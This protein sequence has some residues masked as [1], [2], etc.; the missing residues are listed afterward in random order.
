[1]YE[2]NPDKADKIAKELLLVQAQT[3]WDKT[4]SYAAA[5]QFAIDTHSKSY[6]EVRTADQL[7]I[8]YF[9]L[10]FLGIILLVVAIKLNLSKQTTDAIFLTYNISINVLFGYKLFQERRRV[11]KLRKELRNDKS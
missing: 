7:G 10:M 2:Q 3:D 9:T 11:S 4:A 5:S 1:M 8:P 6:Y